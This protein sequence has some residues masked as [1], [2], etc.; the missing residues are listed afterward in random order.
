[1]VSPLFRAAFH[2]RIIFILDFTYTLSALPMDTILNRVPSMY[3]RIDI[4]IPGGYHTM[5]LTARYYEGCVMYGAAIPKSVGKVQMDEDG[6]SES[7]G[8]VTTE[9]RRYY[10]ITADETDNWVLLLISIIIIIIFWSVIVFLSL[11]SVPSIISQKSTGGQVLV[12]CPVGQCAT[13]IYNGEK[14]CP[15][16]GGTI[17][18]NAGI[19][20][21]SS[22]YSCDNVLLPYAI[23]SDGSIDTTGIC[24]SGVACRCARFPTC[25]EYVTSYF[26][27]EYGNAYDGL[28]G[29]R[30]KFT[31][32]TTWKDAYS[33]VT[34]N[35]RPLQYDSVANNFCT[36]PTQWLSR[37]T[38][39]CTFT[40]TITFDTV[41]QC[42]EN[43]SGCN[44]AT[45]NPC[46]EGTLAYVMDDSSLLTKNSVN[47]VPVGCVAGTP[48]GCGQ[49]AVWDRSYGGIVCK[50]SSLLPD[51]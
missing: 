26:K 42:M 37:S 7:S 3:H 17:V 1:M 39:G 34:S 32:V 31:Q 40:D 29:T 47:I 28:P 13:N 33:G 12:K 43:Q 49:V 14:R 46:M 8:L 10:K 19:E 30:T 48:C 23:K 9:Y 38:P 16:E 24:E 51:S 44:G 4:S 22:K 41:Q 21:C 5:S 45:I 35:N 2:Q 20:V 36:I 6:T 18:S 50:D 15:P 11:T 27:T 25:P